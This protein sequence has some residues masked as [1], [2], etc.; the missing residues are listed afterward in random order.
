MILIALFVSFFF[1]F[2]QAEDGIR[3]LTVTGVQT[4]ALPISVRAHDDHEA[5]AA[6]LFVGSRERQAIH[7]RHADVAQDQVERLGERPLQSPPAVP[8]GRHLVAR[9]DE[10]QPEGLAQPGLVVDHEHPDHRPSAAGKNSLNAAPPSRA[11]S[12]HTTPP[13]S[14]IAR[15]TIASPRPVPWPGSLVVRSEE[16]TSELQS[17]S[18]LVCRLLLEKK[19]TLHSFT[20]L[21]ADLLSYC[22]RE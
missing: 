7:L 6:T 19:K 13:I 3:D 12:T 16:H 1:F 9:V 22:M 4:C 11:R 15:A 20:I 21:D 17:Q 8:L 14:C 18:N 5:S 10:Q 2:F